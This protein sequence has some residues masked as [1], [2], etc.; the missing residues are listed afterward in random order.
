[1][2]CIVHLTIGAVLATALVI[3]CSD[4]SPGDVDAAVCDCPAAEPPVPA[5]IV[6]V[7][8]TDAIVPANNDGSSSATCPAGAK[9]LS[10]GC[11]INEPS[12][13]D[14]VVRGFGKVPDQEAYAC[15]WLNNHIEPQTVFAEATCLVP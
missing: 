8:G 14:I 6:T 7:R 10:G 5:R 15:R 4:D 9:L 12:A 3:S 2:K 13:Q 1:M 11:S